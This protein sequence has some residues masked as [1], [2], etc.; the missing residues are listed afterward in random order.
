MPQ[1]VKGGKF[2]FGW[3]VVGNNGKIKIP[4]KAFKDYSFKIGEKVVLISGS[5]TSGG[6]SIAKLTKL[7]NSPMNSILQ[8][9]EG[10][11]DNKIPNNRTIHYKN[12][13]YCWTT[14]REEDCIILPD[15]IMKTYGIAIPTKVLAVRG[16]GL[17]LSF[18][19]RGS[20]YQEAL[21]HPEIKAF[22]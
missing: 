5:K 6:F 16:S 22:Y 1:L 9:I 13:Y 18:I 20:I 4:P 11:F 15:E 19:S 12:R 17:G 7:Q 8:Q 2:V 14:I 21:H 10:V 3:S